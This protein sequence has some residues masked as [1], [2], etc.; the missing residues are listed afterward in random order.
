[1]PVYITSGLVS[2]SEVN[3]YD[4]TASVAASGSDN[5]DYTVANTTFLLKQITGAASGKM[6]IE[7]QVGPLASLVTKGV[8][9]VSTANPNWAI[10][11]AQPIEVPVASTGTVRIIRTNLESSAMDVYSTIIGSDI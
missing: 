1:M 2:G 8:W 3:D 10:T 4:T 11:F 9:F 6:K 5:H 7:L